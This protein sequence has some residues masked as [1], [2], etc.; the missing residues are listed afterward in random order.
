MY[1]VALF[2]PSMIIDPS[3]KITVTD[4]NTVDGLSPE[5]A[6][7]KL[8]SEFPELESRITIGYIASILGVNKVNRV[9]YIN[10]GDALIVAEIHKNQ[11]AKFKLIEID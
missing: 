10:R 9:P 5:K 4:I 8:S 6:V 11:K 7:T 2:I 1:L 3:A